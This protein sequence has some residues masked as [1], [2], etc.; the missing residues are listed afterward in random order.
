MK[1]SITILVFALFSLVA[2]AQKDRGRKLETGNVIE[3]NSTTNVGVLQSDN[4]QIHRFKH[5]RRS[6]IALGDGVIFARIVKGES[7]GTIDI[8]RT[9]K[10]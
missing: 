10:R 6:K 9:V 4:G 1:K 8:I 5:T 7:G 2:V 3:Y